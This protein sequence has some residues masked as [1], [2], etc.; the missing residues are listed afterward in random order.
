MILTGSADHTARLWDAETGAQVHTLAHADWV[1]S[2]TFSH[3]GQS[4]LT[5]SYDGTAKLW[6]VQTS[7]LLQTFGG[8]AGKV[9]SVVFSPDDQTVL[10]GGYDNKTARLW[11]IHSGALIRML[12]GASLPNSGL[13]FARNGKIVVA[14]SFDG[15]TRLWDV[16]TG[17]EMARWLGTAGDVLAFSADGTLA[18]LGQPDGVVEIR[19]VDYQVLANDACAR[20]FRDPPAFTDA[21]QKLYSIVDTHSIC[22]R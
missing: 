22:S 19:P 1:T 21:D 4:V 18:A 8:G 7:A 16:A 11:D 20:I 13:G 15:A 9:Q 17:M 10:T 12:N 6:N 5:G 3:D 2:A 14:S